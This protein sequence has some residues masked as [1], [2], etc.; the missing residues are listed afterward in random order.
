M[1]RPGFTI[2]ELITVIII[3]CIL[4]TL[5]TVSVNRARIKARDAKRITD[6]NAVHTVLDMF[7]RNEGRYP[8]NGGTINEFEVGRPL[9]SPTTGVT[10]LNKIP[11]NPVPRNDGNCPDQEYQY[12][13]YNNG[14]SYSLEFCLAGSSGAA[15][16]GT[17]Y[18]KPE[19]TACTAQCA[20][21][22]CGPDGCGGVCG[23]GCNASQVCYNG[24]CVAGNCL[25]SSDC[26]FCQDCVSF[27]CA[28]V[29]TDPK[30]NCD[31]SG[32]QTGNCNG[33]GACA[34]YNDLLTHNCNANQNCYGGSCCTYTTSCS[35][36]NK[37]SGTISIGCGKTQTCAVANC[38]SGN[39]CKTTGTCGTLTIT[40]T[41]SYYL[42]GADTAPNLNCSATGSLTGI[43]CYYGISWLYNQQPGEVDIF[44]SCYLKSCSGLGNGQPLN[45]L[46]ESRKCQ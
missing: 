28:N 39:C 42:S 4:A 24:N 25:A 36:Q 17:N 40:R 10:Y 23:P 5:S 8:I 34:T 15:G 29:S 18:V 27:Y 22:T 41:G 31:T 37:C 11:S 2:T 35:A 20:G 38:T 43:C 33:S 19:T 16:A 9:V 46:C 32:C 45:L 30:N 6:A 7:Y 13:A 44:G 12:I 21:K 14:S 1:K 3:I 26:G